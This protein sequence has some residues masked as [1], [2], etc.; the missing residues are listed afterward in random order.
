MIWYAFQTEL[1]VINKIGHGENT[2]KTGMDLD[3]FPHYVFH[4]QFIKAAIL[5][6]EMEKMVYFVAELGIMHYDTL[7]FCRSMLAASAVYAARSTLN[8]SP[9]WNDTPRPYT[10]FSEAQMMDCTKLLVYFRSKAPENKF[11]LVY[12]K[13]SSNS[14]KG[15]VAL[16]PPAKRLVSGDV[17]VKKNTA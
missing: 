17:S 15:A 6:E 2:R 3:S 10:G 12:K 7:M 8:K 4:V 9:A 14:Q 1:T 5:D 13:Y 11:Q 16:I